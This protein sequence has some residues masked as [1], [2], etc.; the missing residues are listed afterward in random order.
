VGLAE[1]SNNL[2]KEQLREAELRAM[3]QAGMVDM[4]MTPSS[5]GSSVTVDSEGNTYRTARGNRFRTASSG[6]QGLVET[7]PQTLGTQNVQARASQFARAAR[8][9]R[10]LR[11]Q[12]ASSVSAQM[13]RQGEDRQEMERRDYEYAMFMARQQEE[14]RRIAQELA[15]AT[16]AASSAHPVAFSSA[17]AAT[18]RRAT[19]NSPR[20]GPSNGRSVV[21]TSC[22]VFLGNSSY[23][24][25]SYIWRLRTY[26]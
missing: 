12:I 25:K 9:P 11:S 2:A 4:A 7:S 17:L 15:R 13:V 22:G 23:N 20:I 16:A 26:C 21:C 5:S 14:E 24:K 1:Q 6:M 19:K 18:T 10:T 3:G 8:D